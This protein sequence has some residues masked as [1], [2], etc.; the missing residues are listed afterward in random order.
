MRAPATR[1]WA[2]KSAAPA[3]R[4]AQGQGVLSQGSRA[5]TGQ[6]PDQARPRP[7]TAR[8]IWT[9]S[10]R[11]AATPAPQPPACR[12]RFA[13]A[14]PDKK[15]IRR[16]WRRTA[17]PA[18]PPASPH[19]IIKVRLNSSA[20]AMARASSFRSIARRFATRTSWPGTDSITPPTRTPKTVSPKR[21]CRRGSPRRWRADDRIAGSPDAWTKAS[22]RLHRR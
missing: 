15:E 18:S 20:A 10:A 7:G 21:Q 2:G 19:S 12:R 4:P 9:S 16:R 5:R 14:G 1:D 8:N 6:Q 3:A 22:N 13:A 11:P 17:C